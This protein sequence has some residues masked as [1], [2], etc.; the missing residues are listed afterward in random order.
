MTR[1]QGKVCL[2]TGSGRGIGRFLAGTFAAEGA[3]LA[4]TSRTKEQLDAV[5]SELH[6]S[7]QTETLCGAVDVAAPGAMADFAGHVRD[8]FGKVDVIVNNAAVIGPVGDLVSL[9][10]DAWRSALTINVV[11][12]A[13]TVAAFAPLVPDGGR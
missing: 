2:I 1:L 12:I 9:D 4:L 10:L 6:H 3:A 13:Q 8:R 5:A 11:G 7:H